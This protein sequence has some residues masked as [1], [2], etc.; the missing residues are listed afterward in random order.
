ML[1]KVKKKFNTKRADS[2]SV[3]ATCSFWVSLSLVSDSLTVNDFA[4]DDSSLAMAL[5]SLDFLLTTSAF[6]LASCAIWKNNVWLKNIIDK[7][8]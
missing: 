7:I 6:A 1:D 4:A 3:S 2:L 8:N 5:L